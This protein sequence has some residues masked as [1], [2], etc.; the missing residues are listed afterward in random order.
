MRL[1]RTV[2]SIAWERWKIIGTQIGSF[3]ARLLMTLFYFT[4]LLAFGLSNTLIADPLRIKRPDF[5]AIR[6]QRRPVR[7]ALEAARRQF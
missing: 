7:E 4:V 1:L 2:L 6:A 3:N 5:A